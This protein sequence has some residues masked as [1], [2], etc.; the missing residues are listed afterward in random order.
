MS[1]K[2]VL[3]L[4]NKK[5]FNILYVRYL[6]LFTFSA[7]FVF[8]FLIYY[9]YNTYKENFITGS[10]HDL[11]TFVERFDTN[12]HESINDF[13]SVVAF[14]NSLP[15]N[16]ENKDETFLTYFNFLLNH[17]SKLFQIRVLDSTGM[18]I[19]R[20]ERSKNKKVK[21]LFN[22]NLQDK[23]DR[24]YFKEMKNLIPNQIY[25]SKIDLN[26]EQGVVEVPFVP[27]FRI[28]TKLEYLENNKPK[29]SY[30]L[31][32][33]NLDTYLALI[34]LEQVSAEEDLIHFSSIQIVDEQGYYL[35]HPNESLEWG[36]DLNH[37]EY[38]FYTNHSQDFFEKKLTHGSFLKSWYNYQTYNLGTHTYYFVIEQSREQ[39]LDLLW[40]HGKASLF[41]F[42]LFYIFTAIIIRN[43]LRA[44]IS[45][46]ELTRKILEKNKQLV[47]MAKEKEEIY[48][49]V[50]HDLRSPFT[51][52]IG[53]SDI[54]VKDYKSLPE[55]QIKHFLI[56]INQSSI[57]TLSMLDNL[58]NWVRS[59]KN[60]TQINKEP[61]LLKNYCDEVISSLSNAAFA[62]NIQIDN[63]IEKGVTV[64]FDK[65]MLDIS[66]RNLLNNAIKFTPE[67]GSILFHGKALK[68]SY[69]LHISD[70]GIGMNKEMLQN[71]FKSGY[72][73]SRQ[74][75][76][77]E[78]GTGL[79][80]AICYKYIK[81]N[82][83]NISVKS[84]K[85]K[86]S[87]FIITFKIEKKKS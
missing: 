28:G 67:A 42:A 73:Q 82:G 32:N 5:Q 64:Y 61:I 18:E 79:G 55:E 70:S 39:I 26:V 80:L 56:L 27:T 34:D 29:N 84:T 1:P 48:S 47:S 41:A 44:S 11:E 74:G 36:R 78:K 71:L 77:L 23:S 87:T 12:I 58:L 76:N 2:K 17:N 52:M 7:L 6:L 69:Q 22:R 19:F 10:T 9:Y 25:Y 49:I 15:E 43:T 66:L 54:L 3:S 86:G 14:I 50:A 35:K 31:F 45:K 53:F 40:M 30:L 62:K 24:D 85:G 60:L 83:A 37:T 20:Q 75:T 59:S 21:F 33:H 68:E 16:V 63:T 65:R 72:K 13:N 8:S 81:A 51:A 4:K 46:G 57:Q 38:N